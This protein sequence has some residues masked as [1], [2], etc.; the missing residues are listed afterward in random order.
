MK[1]WLARVRQTLVSRREFRLE[2]RDRRPERAFAVAGVNSRC[3]P[4]EFD[5]YTVVVFLNVPVAW[6]IAQGPGGIGSLTSGPATTKSQLAPRSRQ[7][8]Q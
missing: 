6:A 2:V 4:D 3:N 7:R 5:D 8:R 1:R